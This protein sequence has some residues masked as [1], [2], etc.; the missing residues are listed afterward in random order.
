MTTIIANEQASILSGPRGIGARALGGA[1]TQDCQQDLIDCDSLQQ[2]PQTLT[3]T[4][5]AIPGFAAA[6]HTGGNYVIEA[7]AADAITLPL[8]TAELDDNLSINIWS[9][10]LFAHTVTLPGVGFAGGAATLKTIATFAAF[11]GAG[12]TLRAWNGT[13]QIIGQ[14]GITL[15]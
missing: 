4:T 1:Y 11:R 13:W 15:S 9:D 6:P 5:D 7:G 14:S 8:P 12:M 2:G 3:G 10:T